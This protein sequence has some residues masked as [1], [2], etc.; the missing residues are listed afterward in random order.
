MKEQNPPAYGRIYSF[1]NGAEG[2]AA[3]KREGE[4]SPSADGDLRNFFEKKFLK[5]LQKTFRY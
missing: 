2:G 4:V 3:L 1:Q 5:D